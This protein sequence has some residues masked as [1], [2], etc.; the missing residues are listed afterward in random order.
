MAGKEHGS[1]HI[2]E[3]RARSPMMQIKSL[4]ATA[5]GIRG[6][7]KIRNLFGD[8]YFQANGGL[9]KQKVASIIFFR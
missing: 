2:S 5:S 1:K 8:E 4:K 6:L 7:Q 3:T 9:D